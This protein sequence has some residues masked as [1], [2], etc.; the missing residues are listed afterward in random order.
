[1]RLKRLN[2]RSIGQLPKS[3]HEQFK[4]VENLSVDVKTLDV[5]LRFVDTHKPG[6]TFPALKR[7]SLH[8]SVNAEGSGPYNRTR[9]QIPAGQPVHC[10]VIG[11]AARE[12]LEHLEVISMYYQCIGPTPGQ[13]AAPSEIPRF[14]SLK[15]FCLE[16]CVLDYT[17]PS[18]LR[19]VPEA[20]RHYQQDPLHDL[21]RGADQLTSLVLLPYAS[22]LSDIKIASLVRNSRNGSRCLTFFQRQSRHRQSGPSISS[23]RISKL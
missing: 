23:L 8:G 7:L 18:P 10:D 13:T 22:T 9:R 3:M 11:P 6:T 21:L 16:S 5:M 17:Y 14:P 20:E 12:T 19:P 1:M 4:S 15:K 2:L